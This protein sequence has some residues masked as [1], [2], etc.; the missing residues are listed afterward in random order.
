M[1]VKFGRAI[2]KLFFSTNRIIWKSKAMKLFQNFQK[3]LSFLVVRANTKKQSKAIEI[4]PLKMENLLPHISFAAGLI[5][6][7]VFLLFRAEK[8][9]EYSETFYPFVTLLANL[10]CVS[11]LLW[12]ATKLFKL[13]DD[14]EETTDE[15]NFYHLIQ[16]QFDAAIWNDSVF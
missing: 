13:I 9:V 12:N 6:T 4:Q 8:F 1:L 16:L 7:S 14:L 3:V 11:I 10:A 15:R 2:R 5:L